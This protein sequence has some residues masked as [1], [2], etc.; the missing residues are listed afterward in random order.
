M[1]ETVKMLPRYRVPI[2]KKRD[3]K[4]RTHKEYIE[5]LNIKNP[6]IEVV[7]EYINASTKIKHHC[8]IHDIYWEI[9][10]ASALQGKGCSMCRN[11]KIGSKLRMTHEEF[12]QTLNNINP[13]ITVDGKYINSGE[14]IKCTCQI[15]NHT[16]NPRAGRLLQGYGCPN[17]AHQNL[18]DKL[19]KTHEQFI[20]ELKVINPYIIIVSEY[21]TNHVKVTCKCKICKF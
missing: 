6:T 21:I 13:T 4:K 1:S 12:I 2:K 16:W 15:C 14:K 11:E 18:A 5:E 3:Y 7:E 9:A 8:L 20:E 10:P 19:R 17:C